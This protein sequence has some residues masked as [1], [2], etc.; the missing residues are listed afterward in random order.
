MKRQLYHHDCCGL[1]ADNAHAAVCEG[2]G[3]RERGSS[4]LRV[5]VR[6]HRGSERVSLA[7][8][9]DERNVRAARQQHAH[10][11]VGR[12]PHSRLR[13]VTDA[14]S[15]DAMRQR[16]S[17][18]TTHDAVD[19][20]DDISDAPHARFALRRRGCYLSDTHECT[21]RQSRQ[22]SQTTAR[23]AR[24]RSGADDTH[25]CNSLQCEPR[26]H[27]RAVRIRVARQHTREQPRRAGR[28]L[29]PWA[30]HQA[31]RDVVQPHDRVGGRRISEAAERVCNPAHR[32]VTR[33]IAHSFK[34]KHA[35]MPL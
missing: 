17:T 32:H 29:V 7:T 8:R 22:I 11:V 19:H 28:L 24:T 10:D 16:N 35:L 30:R 20:K 6:P 27:G 15:D 14:T 25:A 5:G 18:R 2:V 12:P 13:D 3:G 9:N 31:L 33:K 34:T 4:T 23:L 26:R 1:G 21:L